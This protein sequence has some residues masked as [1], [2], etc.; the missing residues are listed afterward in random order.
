VAL[1]ASISVTPTSANFGSVAVGS[2]NS[3]TIQV[4]NTGNAVLTIAQAT[5]TGTGFST[6][7]LDAAT[8]D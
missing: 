8:F 7:G 6:T 1:Q 2:T 4:T 5:V 3:Q